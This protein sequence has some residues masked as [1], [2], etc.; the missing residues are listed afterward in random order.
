MDNK[1]WNLTFYPEN[2][3]ALLQISKDGITVVGKRDEEIP[4]S[5]G[6]LI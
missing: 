3:S 2:I 4:A 1:L 6:V 5:A